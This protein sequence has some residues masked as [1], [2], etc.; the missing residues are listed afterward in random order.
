[1]AMF[2]LETF[3]VLFLFFNVVR[4]FKFFHMVMNSQTTLVTML[5]V[6]FVGSFANLAF[7]NDKQPFQQINQIDM[8]GPT[9]LL[10]FEFF[11]NVSVN[12]N[13]PF[14]PNCKHILTNSFLL[15]NFSSNYLI[16]PKNIFKVYGHLSNTF[17][18]NIV[19]KKATDSSSDKFSNRKNPFVQPLIPVQNLIEWKNG[20]LGR[21]Y[22]GLSASLTY[23]HTFTIFLTYWNGEVISTKIFCKSINQTH[24]RL[25]RKLR[26]FL[27]RSL[28]KFSNISTIQILFIGLLICGDVHPNPGPAPVSVSNN[29]NV[30]AWNV[31]TL[32]ESRRRAERPSAVV[33]RELARYRIDIA[34]LSETRV[35][36]YTSFEEVGG[37]YTFF[38]QGLPK[39]RRREYGVGFAIRTELLPVLDNKFPVG[40]NERL[41]TMDLDIEGGRVHLISAYAPTLSSNNAIKD[42][43]YEELDDLIR[44]VPYSDKLLLLGDLNARVGQD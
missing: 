33:A 11:Q 21:N 26:N 6:I 9:S 8:Q 28:N 25:R 2:L 22:F 15:N 16:L 39:D 43:F 4:C 41:M 10:C 38:L 12:Q 36:E 24:G 13:L 19:S 40:V 17:T 42:R 27:F 44:R 1:M 34:A 29:L 30:A 18:K 23:W 7:S 37:G 14:N 20:H 32:L 31:R 5:L 3:L 35:S